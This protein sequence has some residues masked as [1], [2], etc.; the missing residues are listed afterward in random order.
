MTTRCFVNLNFYSFTNMVLPK[1][2]FGFR[3]INSFKIKK[4]Y[5]CGIS[6]NLKTKACK[7]LKTEFTNCE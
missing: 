1:N 4:K 6:K 3:K 7:N 2:A 5:N